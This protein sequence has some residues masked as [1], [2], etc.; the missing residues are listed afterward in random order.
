LLLTDAK[1][2]VKRFNSSLVKPLNKECSHLTDNPGLNTL[3]NSQKLTDFFKEKNLNPIYIYENLELDSTQKKIKSETLNLSGIYL[4][5]N[6]ITLD[7]YI[8]SWHKPT[9]LIDFLLDF[10]II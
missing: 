2:K 5:L 8:G 6:K 9:L 7:Y 4:I 1:A 3:V 10:L